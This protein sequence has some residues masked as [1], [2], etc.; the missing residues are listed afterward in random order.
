MFALF[1]MMMDMLSGGWCN[2]ALKNMRNRTNVLFQY[3][4]AACFDKGEIGRD[5]AVKRINKEWFA[6][7]L[8]KAPALN[9]PIE[10]A[11]SLPKGS[12]PLGEAADSL[13]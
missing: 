6:E 8:Y 11:Q 9:L 4:T 5:I 13:Y 10:P 12:I 2:S 7:R 1:A 3:R